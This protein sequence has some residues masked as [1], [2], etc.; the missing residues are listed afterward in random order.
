MSVRTSTWV[1]KT[2]LTKYL[3]CPYAFYL[4]D[5]GFVTFED[6]TITELQVRLI[7]EGIEFHDGVEAKAV[8]LPIEPGDLPSVFAEESIRLFG[9]LLFENAKL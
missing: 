7:R 4:L 6:N 8:P 9:V 1:S 3:R 2:D 5:R